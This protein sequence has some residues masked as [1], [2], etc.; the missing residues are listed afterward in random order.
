MSTVPFRW[1]SAVALI[2]VASA[3]HAAQYSWQEPNARVLPTGDIEW[4][5]TPFSFTP[6]PS[7]KYI[8]FEAG[9]DNGDGSK[10][11]PWKHHPWDPAA[12]GAARECAG[13][14]TYV[15]K[16]GATYRGILRPPKGVT[17]EQGTPIQLTIDPAWGSGEARFYGSEQVTG[18]TRGAANSA[19]P[20]R[21][22]V[23]RADLEFAP[24]A[25]WMVGRN[26]AITRIRLARTPNYEASD[27]D[28]VLSE[29]YL[30]ENPRWWT[31]EHKTNVNGVLMHLGIDTKNLA[32]K[33]SDYAGGIVW[34]EWGIV[35]GAPYAAAIEAFDPVQ[36]AI[37]FQGPWQ[38]DSQQ[39]HRNNRY[40]LEDLPQFL[41][42]PGEF[43]FEKKGKGG[44]LYVRLPGD[45]DPNDVTIEAAKNT[46]LIDA[47]A[48]SHVRI[49]GLVFR[50]NNV[51]WDLTAQGWRDPEVKSACIRL[52]GA[53]DDVAIDHCRFESVIQAIRIEAADGGRLD[54]I[55]VA[56]NDVFHTDHDGIEIRAGGREGGRSLGD[57]RVF[58]NRLREIGFRPARVN[59]HMALTVAFPETAEVAGNVIDRCGG[60][61]YFTFGGKGGG[62]QDVPFCRF[63]IH[64]NKVVDPL[65][66][67]NDWGGIETWQGGP[68]YVYNNVSGNPGGLM[69]WTVGNKKEGTPR[70]GHAYY[71]DGA[72]KNYH[73]NNIAWGKNNELGSKYANCAAFQE[74]ISYQN[75]FFNN[76]VY[77]F[78][79]AS[80]R[81][82][83]QAGR[84][85]FMGNIFDDISQIVF[86]HSDAEGKDPNARDAGTQAETFAYE[87]D[88][89]T[90]NVFYAITGKLG[91]FE[92]E[93]GD[94]PDLASFSAALLARKALAAGAGVTTT[95]AVLRDP[96]RHDF[97]LASGSA[98]VD[99]GVKAF[100]PWSLYA[101]VGEWNF[102]RNN[103]DPTVVID[104]HWYMAPY[105]SG[106]EMYYT[107]P[108]YPLKAVGVS[109]A[110]Y[111]DGP[112]EDWTQGA[113]ELDGK[114]QY[115]V[116][117][118]A[119]LAKPFVTG[120]GRG[121]R[122][123]RRGGRTNQPPE[124]AS[125]DPGISGPALKNPQVYTSSMLVEAYL[126]TAQ[127]QTY[128]AIVS[129]MDDK[130][131]YALVLN[132]KGA[133]T[134][135]VMAGGTKTALADS[136]VVNDGA[137]H[138]IIA[139]ADRRNGAMNIYI[140]GKKTVS[141]ELKLAADASL[142]NA[143]DLVAAKGLPCT[144]DFLRIALGTLADAKTT[145]DEL[146]A[147][148]FDGPQF[149]DFCGNAPVA[150]RD[151]GA[152]ELTE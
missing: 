72:F 77:K 136:V 120:E 10:S 27:R 73:F 79:V 144:L 125:A 30:W 106:R 56:D 109:A 133:V 24:R 47:T 25:V 148:Q 115:L 50:F 138:H 140:D 108:T 118:Q 67:A 11:K 44:R 39:I 152:I 114:D 55:L 112:L 53:G 57:V 85:K 38:N 20:D 128:G 132:D 17:G 66:I 102:T 43:W 143:A 80:R 86:R 117:A 147:W 62:S 126:K 89:Y 149:R 48:M 68:F 110:D 71:L 87:T 107:C 105:Y 36:K 42:Q 137:Y 93:D 37:A 46:T 104:E 52:L 121:R 98:A 150:Q 135:S 131:G 69:H 9:D 74:I 81:Q 127:G 90:S 101:M 94:Y 5:P 76:T 123:G 130:A 26:G 113:L 63:L 2:A 139:E 64:H 1:L 82:A 88:A 45:A 32:G 12:M 15:F 134:F 119:D 141:G 65:L 129:K 84:D 83:P 58:R 142:E 28:D 18:W 51:Y 16:R 78:V 124:E 4:T 97:R 49:S 19:I 100:V 103:L 29:W 122:G 35:M 6:G 13:I 3:A 151:A 95:N 54:N 8:D 14:H 145:I 40:S 61:G 146:Y 70:F 41:D 7:V 34:S 75:T 111:V 21:D 116:L 91:V 22:K 59:G 92:A 23:W 31:G 99:C 60:S 33:A 96:A